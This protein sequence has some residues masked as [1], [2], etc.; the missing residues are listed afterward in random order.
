[1]KKKHILNNGLEE[2]AIEGNYSLRN[3]VSESFY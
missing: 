1:M 3:N 2:V